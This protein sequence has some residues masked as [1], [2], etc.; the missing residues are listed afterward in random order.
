MRV[1][2][3]GADLEENLALGVLS[4]V[5]EGLG[6]TAGVVAFDDGTAVDRVARQALAG[7]PDVI[8]LSMQFQHRAAEF[9]ALA[10]RLRALGFR[11]HVTAGGQLATLA[12]RDTLAPGHGIDSVVLH[13]GEETLAE[14]LGAIERG[15]P[16][17]DVAGLAI[18]ADDGAPMRTPARRLLDDLD[19]VPFPRRY[20]AHSRH[21]GV[22]FIPLMGGRGCWGHC[23]Y[24]A[25]VAYYR[26]AIDASGGGRAVRMRSPEN[27]AAEMALLLE[28][29]GGRAIFCFHD[30]NFVFPS[31][32]RS[33]ERVRAI[34]RE[35]DRYGGGDVAIVAKARPDCITAAVA[36]EL[37]EAGCVRL[38][39][40]V[41]N[42]SERGGANLGR[43]KQ[44]AH[45]REAIAACREAGIALC[46]NLLLFEPDATLDD[47]RDN[48]RFMR[49]HADTPVNFCRAEPYYGT[50]LHKQTAGREEL[51]GGGLGFNYRLAD[52]RA[53]LCFRVCSAA[54]R[55]RNFAPNGV[56]NRSMGLGYTAK[57]VERFH[58]DAGAREIARR[59]QALTRR[60]VL[61]TAAHLE[62]A[63]AIAASVDL[64]DEDTIARETAA[65]GL[66]VAAADRELHEAL[67]DLHAEV[68]RRTRPRDV[69]PPPPRRATPRL[70][71][72]RAA[73]AA[74][75]SLAVALGAVDGCGNTVTDGKGP[76]VMDPPAPDWDAGAGGAT[77][78]DPAV[79]D[80]GAGGNTVV[81]PPPPD[82][83]V[84]GAGGTTVV[85]PPPPDAGTGGAGAGGTGTGGVGG[86]GGFGGA[87]GSTVV[88]PPPP[89]GGQSALPDDGDAR[90]ATL[91]P[92]PR[93]PS[94]I[95]GPTR[96]PRSRRAR[97]TCPSSRRRAPRSR[98]RRREGASASAPTAAA[99]PCRRAGRPRAPSRAT[100]SRS[101][102]SRAARTIASASRCARAAA[103]PSSRSRR[104]RPPRAPDQRWTW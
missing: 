12:W 30:D 34:R 77:V 22:P 83:G 16:L 100:A 48:A 86:A 72:L 7:A 80:A 101:S 53:E 24:C 85:D 60:V 63:I 20:R 42:A 70:A 66:S 4:A 44:Q 32:A 28:R 41:E 8:G 55:E 61:D 35:L 71:E 79:Y 73:L 11:G 18:R 52:D 46:Y 49:D 65:L 84:G 23:S 91:A 31:E 17:A 96:P 88:D 75:V 29:A 14:L 68:V 78:V 54:F 93:L 2:L 1:H 19:A 6:H 50:I 13:D 3:I 76:V 15:T 37:A 94:S 10:R 36:R 33:I 95:A 82:A 40:G 59:A 99:W 90:L 43:G 25:I 58:A 27:V 57:L 103:W 47:V 5:V 69:A 26:D 98:P 81:D 45:V 64:A 51:G 92:K 74:G 21:L 104:S 9:H 39:L 87:G 38:Y 89:D 56:A 62:Q 97:R 102:G 67:D